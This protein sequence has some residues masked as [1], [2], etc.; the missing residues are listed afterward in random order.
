MKQETLLARVG[1]MSTPDEG[2]QI[3]GAKDDYPD[4]VNEVPV[5]LNRLDSKAALACEITT[6]CTKEAD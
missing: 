6:N 5:H 1:R 3:N 4:T 2:K